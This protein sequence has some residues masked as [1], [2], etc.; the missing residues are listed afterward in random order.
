MTKIAPTATVDPHA[1][2]A[3]DVEVGPGSYVGPKVRIGPGCRLLANVT[4]LGNT[5]IG[6]GNVFYPQSVIGA[7]PQDLKYQGTDTELIIGDDNVFRESMTVHTGT[8]TGGGITRI[9]NKNQFQVGSHLGHDVIVGDHC[10]LSNLVQIAGHVQIEDCVHISGLVGVQQ[11][12]TLGRNCYVTGFARCTADTPP[13]V[14]YSHDG[15][16]QGVNVKGLA[17]WGFAESSIQQLRELGK[18]LFPR[19]NQ[20]LNDFQ[21]RGLYALLPW[22]KPVT[23]GVATLTKRLREAESRNFADEHCNY[24]LNFLKRSIHEGVHG[25]Y[26]ESHRRDGAAKP[27]FYQS[28]AKKKT[29]APSD[30]GPSLGPAD[31]GA[32]RSDP[33]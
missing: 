13:F 28:D 25:R 2:L 1:E 14:I 5:R 27:K 20:I 9:G 32:I 17:R 16:V 7:A 24:L 19:K 31:L 21:P 3:P 6:S 18:I 12:V 10:I 23:D 8:E 15:T 26:L 4:I 30:A 22:K 11:F 29:S 33:A